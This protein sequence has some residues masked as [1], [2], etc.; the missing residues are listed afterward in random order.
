MT[1]PRAVLEAYDIDATSL[2]VV[3]IGLV[4]RTWLARTHTGDRVVLQRLHAAFGGTVNEDIDVITRHLASRG[5]VTPRLVRT[6]AGA[7]FVEDEGVYR[8]I[9]YLHGVTHPEVQS[10]SLAAAAAGLVARVHAALEGFTHDFAFTWPSAHDTAKHLARLDEVSR[11]GGDDASRAIADAILEHARTLEPLPPTR[12]RIV[13]GDLK[14]TNVLFTP[15]GD[16]GLALVDLDTFAVGSIPVEMG[17]AFRSWS[18]PR[19]ESDVT[20]EVSI[21]IFEAAARAYLAGVR[22]DDD[23]RDALV[24]GTETIATELAA[25]FCVDAF[26]DRYFGYDSTRFPS[27]IAHN[28]VRARSQLAL[29]V[30]V[31]SARSALERGV[32][33]VGSG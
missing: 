15:E 12:P 33:H 16:E 18:N 22:L 7:A 24:L 27:R 23:E 3:S 8:V 17:D 11:A 28:R 10:P 4:N 5:L 6:R 13:H 31:R 9:T 25:R 20:A 14:I 29:A 32:R 30:S 19:G 21:P 2:S 1:V 26:E